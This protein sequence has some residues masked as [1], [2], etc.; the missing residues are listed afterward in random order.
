MQYKSI[1]LKLLITSSKM[2]LFLFYLHLIKYF[3]KNVNMSHYDN[4]FFPLYFFWFL[5]YVSLFLC[6]YV[7]NG[8][9]VYLLCEWYLFSLKIFIFCFI[10]KKK[11][12]LHYVAE[13]EVRGWNAH[14]DLR[15]S[16]EATFLCW[17][18]IY[19]LN[20][21]HIFRWIGIS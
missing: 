3:Q 20:V 19:L 8:Y 7:F 10:K 13:K 16:N 15:G 1:I 21:S 17:C 18:V 9:D 6:C 11:K 5:L 12:E 14:F 4:I 2:L